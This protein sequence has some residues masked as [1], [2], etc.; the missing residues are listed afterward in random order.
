[1]TTTYWE[2]G[3]RIVESEQEGKR[4]AGYGEELL[5]KLSADLTGRFGRGFSPD[6]LENMRRFYMTYKAAKI[7]ETVSRKSQKPSAELTVRAISEPGWFHKEE[8]N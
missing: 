1:M 8:T 2:I 5:K 4:R 7:S 6:N 3:R